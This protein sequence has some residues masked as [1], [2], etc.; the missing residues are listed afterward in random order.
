MEVQLFI[1][2]DV[3]TASLTDDGQGGDGDGDDGII[4]S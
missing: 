4:F 3:I 2:R 1:M